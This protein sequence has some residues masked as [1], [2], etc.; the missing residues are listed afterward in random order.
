MKNKE[1]ENLIA[2]TRRRIAGIEAQRQ[3]AEANKRMKQV[4]QYTEW[5]K[6]LHR[7]LEFLTDRNHKERKSK[8]V[9][10]SGKI[11]GDTDYIG[12]FASAE[13]KLLDR[14]WRV[15]NPAKLPGDFAY[16]KYFPINCAMIDGAD[17]IYMLRDFKE[18]F[19]AVAELL[20]AGRHD[21]EVMFEREEI[22][23]QESAK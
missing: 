1:R 17:A 21:I 7:V 8:T 11:T 4:R 20:Y 12:K 9:Y 23:K 10:I 18:S 15:L 13:K 5:I 3:D 19:G 2:A 6:Y 14:G 16:E 22:G